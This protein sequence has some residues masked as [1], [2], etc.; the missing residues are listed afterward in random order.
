MLRFLSD[1]FEFHA[2]EAEMPNAGFKLNFRQDAVNCP[3]F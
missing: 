2:K 1:D 3:E